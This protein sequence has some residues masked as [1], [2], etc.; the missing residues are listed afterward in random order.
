MQAKSV[1][2][3]ILAVL[4]SLGLLCLIFPNDGISF[5]S[6]TLKFP[7]IAEVI[8]VDKD[9]IAT[10]QESPKDIIEKR[11][12]DLEIAKENEFKKF[13]ETS[14]ARFFL[15]NNDIAYLDN[16]FEALDSASKKHVRILHYG[17]S[18][19]ECDRISCDLRSR[20]QEQFG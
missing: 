7:S 9:T 13:C 19:L 15:P 18:Q 11:K 17:D 16:F 8:S 2:K 3:F 20:F 1:L 4:A 14:P 5:F 12:S 10:P 6:T